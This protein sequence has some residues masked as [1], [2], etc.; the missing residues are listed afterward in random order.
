MDNLST[1]TFP[2][3][4]KF[5]K[6]CQFPHRWLVFPKSREIYFHCLATLKLHF[7]Y[8]KSSRLTL[9]LSL[10]SLSFTCMLY[11]PHFH[12]YCIDYLFCDLNFSLPAHVSLMTIYKRLRKRTEVINGN[13]ILYFDIVTVKKL[14]SIFLTPNFD[15][16][17]WIKWTTIYMTP[18]CFY[19]MSFCKRSVVISQL[20]K[21]L[22]PEIQS[23]DESKTQIASYRGYMVD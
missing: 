15:N 3:S 6:K 20:Q 12:H 16:K 9:S 13:D 4:P 8:T 1:Q 18:M 14:L 11:S 2:K 7:L 23:I 17:K 22:H 21:M 19:Y 10:S 5:L